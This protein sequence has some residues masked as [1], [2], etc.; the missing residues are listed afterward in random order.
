MHLLIALDNSSLNKQIGNFLKEFMDQL[1]EKPV[2]SFIHV[3]D[4]RFMS[5]PRGYAGALTY[6]SS[7]HSVPDENSFIRKLKKDVYKMI[8]DIQGQLGV[9]GT[10]DFPVDDPFEALMK[11]SEQKKPDLLVVGNHSRKGIDHFLFGNFAEKILRHINVPLIIVGEKKKD[12]LFIE[13]KG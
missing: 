4:S 10:I 6:D 3:I 5:I 12:S 13:A 8:T 2:L 7:G 11:A 1:K 9:K